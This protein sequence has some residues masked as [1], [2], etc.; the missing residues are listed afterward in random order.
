M[1]PVCMLNCQPRFQGVLPSHRAGRYQKGKKPW[2]R[3][4]LICVK[5]G[6]TF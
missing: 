1:L 5:V 4:L 3:G 2:K 6:K